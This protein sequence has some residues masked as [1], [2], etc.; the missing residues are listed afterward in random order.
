MSRK[1]MT[2]PQRNYLY[3]VSLQ[4]FLDEL[5]SLPISDTEKRKRM[6]VIWENAYGDLPKSRRPDRGEESQ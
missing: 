1:R 4:V 2:M 5:R 3:K 6:S